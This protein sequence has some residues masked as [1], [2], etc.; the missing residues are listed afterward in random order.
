MKNYFKFF[1]YLMFVVAFTLNSC[2]NDNEDIIDVNVAKS[3]QDYSS[4]FYDGFVG[5][6][7]YGAGMATIGSIGAQGIACETRRR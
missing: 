7:I 1:P 3:T 4:Y 6:F 5:G 2:S